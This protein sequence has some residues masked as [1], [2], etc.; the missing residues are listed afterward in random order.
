MANLMCWM[1]L[2]VDGFIEGPNREFDRPVLKNDMSSYA[3]DEIR[4]AG[5]FLYG[6]VVWDVMSGYWPTADQQPSSGDYDVA[7]AEI[8]GNTPKIVFSKTF[9]KADWNTRVVSDD[10]AG[11]VGKLKQEPT[12]DLVGERRY[13]S[14]GSGRSL[15][16]PCPSAS[17]RWGR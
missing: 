14:P 17:V 9:E 15:L 13:F 11:E 10:I 12:K 1:Q 8:W 4:S 6:R 2:S 16:S 7:Y 5:T 3:L